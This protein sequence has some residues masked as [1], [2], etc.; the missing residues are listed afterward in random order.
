M[1]GSQ[2][3]SSPEHL[4]LL[5]VA[6]QLALK[7]WKCLSRSEPEEVILP[8]I[9]QN[10]GPGEP[11]ATW[12]K[13]SL[14]HPAGV[15]CHFW[16]QGMGAYHQQSSPVNLDYVTECKLQI[17]CVL[18][19]SSWFRLLGVFVLGCRFGALMEWEPEWTHT[20]VLRLLL[21][22]DRD[23]FR[24]VWAGLLS[25]TT[26]VSQSTARELS[27]AFLRV[28]PRLK[29]ELNDQQQAKFVSYYLEMFQL[30][31]DEVNDKWIP[32]LFA[33]GDES[34]RHHFARAITNALRNW[35]LQ[36]RRQAWECWIQQYWSERAQY[37]IPP[38]NVD[39]KEAQE[40]LSWLQYLSFVF[41]DAVDLAV[42]MPFQE[43]QSVCMVLTPL[44]K[45]R[46]E[47][48][49]PPLIQQYPDAIARLL[50]AIGHR[51]ASDPG[52]QIGG[53]PIM[54]QL[55]SSDCISDH[56]YGATQGA[57][58]SNGSYQTDIS[59]PLRNQ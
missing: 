10:Q 40:S 34:L 52:W 17:L 4:S 16:V 12:D 14:N 51:L 43:V 38:P 27:T 21:A 29:G 49:E 55:I 26:S 1:Y 33:Q 13:K 57:C 50:V 15:L 8:W 28:L 37:N 58:N 9:I 24:A 35:N 59:F 42:Q 32:P 3:R 44:G 25:G 23:I 20:H 56:I 46:K 5:P 30:F 45:S 18:D 31:P 11:E 48:Q 41:P 54:D 36:S 7:L 6:H 39:A 47:S 22:N 19:D 53:P 2:S